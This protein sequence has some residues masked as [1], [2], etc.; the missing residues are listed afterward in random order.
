MTNYGDEEIRRL[1]KEVIPHVDRELRHDLWPEMLR[2]LETPR[3]PVPWY[4]WAL[5]GAL[6]CWL[7]VV[8]EGIVHLL[9]QL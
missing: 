5:I 6:A 1:V 2:R 3:P 4:D 7:V 9:Y 8:P